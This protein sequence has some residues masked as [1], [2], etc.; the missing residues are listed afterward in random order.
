MKKKKYLL[1]IMIVFAL[2]AA[3]AIW[4]F[5]PK[6]FLSGVEPSDIKSIAVFDGNTGKGFDINDADEIRYIIE[7]IQGIKMERDNISIGY[8]GVSFRMHFYDK[9]GKKI[10]SF[11]M[12]SAN[13]I[14]KDPFFYRCDDNLCFDYLKELEDKYTD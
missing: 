8:L 14:R 12:N 13:T 7:N 1:I 11:T 9:T 2:A 10:E 5:L 4:Y 3:S 6:T